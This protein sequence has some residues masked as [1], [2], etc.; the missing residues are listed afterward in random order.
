MA[1]VW[2][3]VSNKQCCSVKGLSV[4]VGEMSLAITHTDCVQLL[5]PTMYIKYTSILEV[6]QVEG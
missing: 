1:T 4:C 2:K 5:Q 3:V 6:H